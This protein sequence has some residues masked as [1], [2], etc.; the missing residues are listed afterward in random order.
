MSS[1]EVTR[2]VVVDDDLL[3]TQALALAWEREVHLVLLD[4]DLPHLDGL[5]VCR[6]LRADPRLATIPIML[7]TGQGT[8]GRAAG[9]PL[10]PGD[11]ITSGVTD[12]LAKPFKVADLRRRARS[13][14]TSGPGES[15]P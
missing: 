1:A 9:H 5:E 15:A 13:L 7:M 2:V 12:Y 14:L 4:L 11:L 10:T 6:R 3:L 8:P